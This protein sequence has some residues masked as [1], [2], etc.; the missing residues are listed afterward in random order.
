MPSHPSLVLQT[1]PSQRQGVC[2]CEC[3]Y[4][5]ISMHLFLSISLCTYIQYISLINLLLSPTCQFFFLSAAQGAPAAV[6]RVSEVIYPKTFY[7]LTSNKRRRLSCE[8]RQ[9]SARKMIW[10]M[11]ISRLLTG[12]CT[13]SLCTFLSQ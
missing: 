6:H 13:H 3:V 4:I 12:K 5:S 2:V 10:I 1:R 7:L 9:M 8:L 11:Q